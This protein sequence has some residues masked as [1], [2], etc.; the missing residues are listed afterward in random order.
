MD[1]C[2][3]E[4]NFGTW[5]NLGISKSNFEIP[6]KNFILFYFTQIHFYW[7]NHMMFAGEQKS[8]I[9]IITNPEYQDKSILLSIH[10][11]TL[12]CLL[13]QIYEDKSDF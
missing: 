9:Q 12:Q 2:L 5:E 11:F 7:K 4:I 8:F 1:D 13:R 3:K 10:G 6:D